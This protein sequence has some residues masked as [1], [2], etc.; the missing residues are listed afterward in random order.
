MK[1]VQC[2]NKHFFDADAYA[3]C[4]HCGAAPASADTPDPKVTE[5]KSKSGSKFK[6]PFFGGH[7]QTAEPAAPVYSVPSGIQN[8]V[9]HTD[10]GIAPAPSAPA[11]PAPVDPTPMP[12]Q[13]APDSHTISIHKAGEISNPLQN[14]S[15]PAYQPTRGIFNNGTSAQSPASTASVPVS[16]PPVY[17]DRGA[18][19]QA[20]LVHGMTVNK[21]PSVTNN[22]VE[23]KTVGVFNGGKSQNDPVAGWL[24]CLKGANVGVSFELYAKKNTIGRFMSNDIV[25][26][27]EP[28]VSRESHAIINFDYKKSDFYL[29]PS[30]GDSPY[31]NDEIV[32]SAV[33][34]SRFDKIEIG[35]CLLLFV[36]L[37][38]SDFSWDDYLNSEE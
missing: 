27:N 21:V 35:G 1:K 7:K 14:Q 25:L 36:P 11:E 15:D 5:N 20:T 28:R 10:S 26:E 22:S 3:V 37:C 32:L 31:I 33:K 24:V 18:E 19:Y 8:T 17:Q 16:T 30:N 2:V 29:L 9:P 4:P 23:S 6:M 38:G 34:L 13:F 12:P